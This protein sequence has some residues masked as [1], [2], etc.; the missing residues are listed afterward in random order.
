MRLDQ[1]VPNIITSETVA[2]CL[3]ASEANSYAHA[4]VREIIFRLINREFFDN[5]S[6]KRMPN[7]YS[8]LGSLRDV[9]MDTFILAHVIANALSWKRSA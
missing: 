4:G 6:E 1:N 5:I 7:L 3:G 9:S 8:L 2:Q